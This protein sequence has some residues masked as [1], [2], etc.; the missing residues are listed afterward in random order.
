MIMTQ[1]G[2]R[3]GRARL[4]VVAAWLLVSLLQTQDACA[5][6][7]KISG[8]SKGFATISVTMMLPGDDPKHEI[9]LIHSRYM[10]SSA[11]PD[12]DSVQFTSVTVV[13]HTAGTGTLRG[14]DVGTHPSGDQHFTA[15]EGMVKTVTK[16]DGS[17]E[18]TAEGKWWFTGG[19]G[20]FK[21]ITGGGTFKTKVIPGKPESWTSEWEGAYE[22]K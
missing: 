1:H 16:P 11:D 9:A 14:Y 4:F 19:T 5:E 15:G 18:T 3:W 2:C 7:K 22:I 21:G 13:D 8:T 10:D 12:F 6:G 17:P 20:K